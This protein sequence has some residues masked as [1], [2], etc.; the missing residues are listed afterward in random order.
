MVAPLSAISSLNPLWSPV[1]VTGKRCT[2]QRSGRGP[3]PAM[4]PGRGDREEVHAEFR[5]R[6]AN[7]IPL[8][9]PV[10]VT[11]KSRR[12]ADAGPHRRLPAMEPG[13]GDRE[14]RGG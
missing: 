10:A 4:E 6:W 8:W 9:S 1:A 13:R 11:G 5:R 3:P 14:E 2:R 12:L 7:D